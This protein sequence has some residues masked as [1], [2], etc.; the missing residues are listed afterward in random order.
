MVTSKFSLTV[1]LGVVRLL[2]LGSRL[3]LKSAHLLLF[4]SQRL[5]QLLYSTIICVL[6]SGRLLLGVSFSELRHWLATSVLDVLLELFASTLCHLVALFCLPMNTLVGV[7][8]LTKLDDVLVT[9]VDPSRQRCED[10]PVLVEYVLIR[11]YLLL[12]F[13]ELFPFSFDFNKFF[14]VLLSDQHRLLF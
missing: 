5:F 13:L 1:E 11:V 14:L 4:F 2:L 9:F 10:V 3:H 6:L 8:F 12:V 7:Q